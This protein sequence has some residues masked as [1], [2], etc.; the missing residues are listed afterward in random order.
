[1][2]RKNI[3]EKTDIKPDA[4]NPGKHQR[5]GGNFHYAGAAASLY[6]FCEV[7][8]N[9]IGFRRRIGGRD[10]LRS[11]Q[12]AVG[13]DQPRLFPHGLQDPADHIAGGGLSLGPRNA[14]GHKL[15]GRVAEP[16]GGKLRQSLPAVFHQ[17]DRRVLRKG[18][19]PLH[20]EHPAP[21]RVRL[22]DK[23]MGIPGA[24]L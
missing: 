21:G 24:S 10:P 22:G 11:D 23:F 12:N 5:L 13:A 9:Q 7:F 15:L 20:H 16:G 6:H 4:P 18:N 2:I 19:L 8:L 14:D 3:G 17:D 1:M